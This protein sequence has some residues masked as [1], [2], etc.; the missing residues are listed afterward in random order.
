MPRCFA[1]FNPFQ[2]ANSHVF[3]LHCNSAGSHNRFDCKSKNLA[4][5]KARTR[6]RIW[7]TASSEQGT[8]LDKA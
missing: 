6:F 8:G 2:D 4:T 3:A 7:S 1:V 5:R